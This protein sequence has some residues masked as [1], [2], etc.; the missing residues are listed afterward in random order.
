MKENQLDQEFDQSYEIVEY[1]DSD[2]NSKGC[3]YG[4]LGV[5]GC[6]VIVIAALAVSGRAGH[7]HLQHNGR[8]CYGTL[9]ATRQRSPYRFPQTQSSRVYVL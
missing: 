7:Y 5:G 9:V 1:I 3:L 4:F 2:N 6:L 8:S